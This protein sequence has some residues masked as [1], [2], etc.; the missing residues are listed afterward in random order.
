MLLI[1]PAAWEICFNQSEALPRSRQ[2]HVISKDFSAP[3]PQTPFCGKI[4]DGLVKCRLF[5]QADALK[6]TGIPLDRDIM[7]DDLNGGI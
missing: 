2:G 5:S 7:Q 3:V 1:G 6:L 4:S